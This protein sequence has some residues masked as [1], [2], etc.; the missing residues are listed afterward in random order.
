MHLIAIT[1]IPNPFR[2]T[3]KSNE[4]EKLQN[5]KEAL[6][7]YNRIMTEPMPDYPSDDEEETK[8]GRDLAKQQIINMAKTG[9]HCIYCSINYHSSNIRLIICSLLAIN[10]V[11]TSL[12]L[13]IDVIYY[14]SINVI[15][16]DTV[17]FTESD[18]MLRLSL[19]HI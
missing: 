19:I 10:G 12:K 7:M 13:V 6:E 5:G 18:P 11:V 15:S 8:Q 9:I 3:T 2:K 4:P 14:L 16:L 1:E 17:D